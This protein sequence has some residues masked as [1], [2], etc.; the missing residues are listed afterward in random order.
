MPYPPQI[1]TACGHPRLKIVQCSF[2]GQDC[3]VNMCFGDEPGNCLLAIGEQGSS[4]HDHWL[5]PSHY[6]Q[7]PEATQSPSYPV[8][9]HS[10]VPWYRLLISNQ[11]T[12][13]PDLR[14]RHCLTGGM[15]LMPFLYLHIH[16]GG[17]ANKFS[18]TMKV[19]EYLRELF[20]S[21]THVLVGVKL[22]LN[23]SELNL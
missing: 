23:V 22:S 18:L 15:R 13:S 8:I 4:S 1:C 5:C 3:P 9:Q 6:L 7:S 12:L 2:K 14:S 16:L 19:E 20:K 11:Y 21:H 17:P 10:F